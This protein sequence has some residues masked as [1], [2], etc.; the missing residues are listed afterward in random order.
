MGW[1]EVSGP[2]KVLCCQLALFVHTHCNTKIVGH[3]GSYK[4]SLMSWE[5]SLK[6]QLCWAGPS[7]LGLLMTTAPFPS[8]QRPQPHGP[9]TF[10][11]PT[12]ACFLV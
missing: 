8:P 6:R 2:Y 5:R 1:V 9:G 10:Y 7:L 12:W 11:I 3:S 4:A